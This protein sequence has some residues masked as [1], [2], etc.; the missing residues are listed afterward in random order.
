MIGIGVAC[1]I[2]MNGD[3]TVSL[4]AMPIGLWLLLTKERVMDFRL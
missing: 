3:A 2:L 1:P 4:V